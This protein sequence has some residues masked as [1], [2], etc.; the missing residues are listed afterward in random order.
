MNTLESYSKRV[1]EN[2][3]VKAAL[4]FARYV[5]NSRMEKA[6]IPFAVGGHLKIDP[7]L[8]FKKADELRRDCQ[9]RFA[10]HRDGRVKLDGA[11]Y[12]S[13]HEKVD[14]IGE[15]VAKLAEAVMALTGSK[16]A[17]G[18]RIVN[19]EEGKVA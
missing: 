10:V 14:S 13:L 6:L 19:A 11:E 16:V 2:R 3:D 15:Q 12:E 17:G 4:D 9:E 7:L 8:L 18:L 1:K 5:L